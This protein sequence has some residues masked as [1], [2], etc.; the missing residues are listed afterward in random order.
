MGIGVEVEGVV[1]ELAAAGA[2]WGRGAKELRSEPGP[3]VVGGEVG[4]A[5]EADFGASGGRGDRREAVDEL[6]RV[7]SPP[8]VELETGLV[9]VESLV[10]AWNAEE[11][12][13]D[14]A[15]GA[16]G[17]DE[18]GALAAVAIEERGVGNEAEAVAVLALQLDHELQVGHR[19]CSA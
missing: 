15:G 18:V 12:E 2:F 11:K 8:V 1:V 7:F 6:G 14:L 19:V 17:A 5:A 16:V 4:C 3:E 10:R 13:A 9:D